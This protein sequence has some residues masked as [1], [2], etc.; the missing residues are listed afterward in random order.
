LKK[1]RPRGLSTVIKAPIKKPDAAPAA[2]DAGGAAAPNSGLRT[3]RA[4]AVGK[5]RQKANLLLPKSASSKALDDDDEL[6][7]PE[8]AHQLQTPRSS[9]T[10]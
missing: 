6:T 8:E 1:V 3:R 9:K 5:M 7:I 2:A 10:S 4:S